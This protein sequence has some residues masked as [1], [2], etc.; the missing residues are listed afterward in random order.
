M[1]KYK[2][3]ITKVIIGIPDIRRRPVK[4]SMIR[5]IR[6]QLRGM[7]PNMVMVV[8]RPFQVP[9]KKGTDINTAMEH[10]SKMPTGS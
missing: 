5:I 1:P 6:D 3:M 7:E 8:G 10:G 9:P 4:I 2:A